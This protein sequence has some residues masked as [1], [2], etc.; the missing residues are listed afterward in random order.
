MKYRKSSDEGPTL[1]TSVLVFQTFYG[2]KKLS[3]SQLINSIFVYLSLTDTTPQFLSNLFPSST[4]WIRFAK[5]KLSTLSRINNCPLYGLDYVT[6]YHNFKGFQ[7][8]LTYFC[9]NCTNFSKISYL[10]FIPTVCI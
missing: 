10:L 5:P 2:G 1:E 6:Y 7:E 8:R 3:M 9:S 4:C